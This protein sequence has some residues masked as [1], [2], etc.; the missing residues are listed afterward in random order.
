MP[1]AQALRLCPDLVVV[2]ANMEKYR[3]ES[4]RV[5][6]IFCGDTQHW[7]S[8]FRWTKPFWMSAN[9]KHHRGSATRIAEEIR[10]RVREEVRHHH[11]CGYRAK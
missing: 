10:N 9:A 7:W 6:S 2:P 4:K 1:M 8:H 11:F 3:A 5:Q